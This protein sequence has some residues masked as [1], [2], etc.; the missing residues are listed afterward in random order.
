MDSTGKRATTSKEPNLKN[1][2][3]HLKKNSEK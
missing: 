1:E 3:T 2:G